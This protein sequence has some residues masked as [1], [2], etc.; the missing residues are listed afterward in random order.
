MDGAVKMMISFYLMWSWSWL[1]HFAYERTQYNNR[2]CFSLKQY[3]IITMHCFVTMHKCVVTLAML[4]TLRRIVKW[5]W[6]RHKPHGT[7]DG[8]HA[9]YALTI[10]SG[11]CWLTLAGLP[12]CYA[13][14][15]LICWYA[16]I[17]SW[18]YFYYRNEYLHFRH[19]LRI[20]FN[21]MFGLCVWQFTIPMHFRNLT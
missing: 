9:V 7:R 10:L 13:M 6:S 12:C 11:R 16:Y 14:K 4:G 3:T 19:V 20:F 5:C 17:I 15:S 2:N 8:C 21:I 18:C 1:T